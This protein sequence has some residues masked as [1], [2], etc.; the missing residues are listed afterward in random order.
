MSSTRWI[1][2]KKET[3]ENHKREAKNSLP[4]VLG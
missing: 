1:L 3:G 2:V 4:Y